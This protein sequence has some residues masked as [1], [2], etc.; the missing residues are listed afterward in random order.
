MVI[1][2][3][4]QKGGV[5]KTTTAASVSVLLARRGGRVL[6]VDVDPQRTLTRQLGVTGNV[7]SLVDVL[8]GRTG[9]GDAI[10]R[11]V[12]GLSLLPAGRDLAGIERA[13]VGELGRE[14]YLA[15]AL[16][17]VRAG[18]DS[19]VIDCPPNLGLLTVNALMSAD[20]VLAPVS[21]DDEASVQ[22]LRELQATIGKLERLRGD[23]PALLPVLTRWQ[24]GRIVADLVAEALA[25]LDFAPAAKIPDR[26]AV[27]QAAALHVPLAHSAPDHAVTLAYSRVVD[28]LLGERV[29]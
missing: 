12:F 15:D 5:G 25:A 21:A 18:Y 1:A 6:A 29:A 7:L 9:A 8:A 17:N 22:G 27:P 4:N 10:V 14:R 2:I 3:A 28:R 13:L 26:A 23:Q 11:D 20:L 16:A 24:S 19:I